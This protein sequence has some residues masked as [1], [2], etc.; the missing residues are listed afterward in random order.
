MSSAQR[1]SRLGYL[2]LAALASY[3]FTHLW[4]ELTYEFRGAPWMPIVNGTAQTPFQYRVL[5]PWIV[6]LLSGMRIA[7][8][9]PLTIPSLLFWGEFIAVFLLVFAF[10]TYL[11]FFWEERS[12][13]LLSF[14]LFLVLPYNLILNRVLALRYPSDIPSILFFTLGLVLLHRRNWVLFYPLLAVAT[15]NRE[16][17]CFLTVA[18][19]AVALGREKGTRIAL[20]VCAQL[21]LWCAIKYWLHLLYLSNPGEGLCLWNV[22]ANLDFLTQ[23]RA[24]PLFLSNLGYCWIPVLLF[25]RRIPDCFVRRTVAVVPVFFAGM[26]LV[27]NMWELRIYAELIPVVLPALFLICREFGRGDSRCPA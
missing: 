16:T 7:G 1:L 11:R 4:F 6:R 10:R 17:S 2:V 9:G 15:L 19:V 25:W 8:V 26:F 23:P 5:V 24:Y 18:Y 14:S 20:Q 12:A 3:Y 21:L 27:G 13:C 22:R